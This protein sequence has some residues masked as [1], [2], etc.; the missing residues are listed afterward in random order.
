MVKGKNIL[1]YIKNMDDELIPISCGKSCTLSLQQDYIRATNPND[2]DWKYYLPT[3]RSWSITGNGLTDFSKKMGIQQL[4]QYLIDRASLVIKFEAV[5]EAGD[6]VVYTGVG[7]YQNNSLVG[8]AL[9]L[10][11]FSY[12]IIGIG[13]IEIQ[14][15]VPVDDGDGGGG[16]ENMTE[17]KRLQF[18]ATNGQTAYQNVDLIGATLLWFSVESNDLYKGSGDYEMAG[19]DSN[20]GVLTWNYQTSDGNE[21]IMLYKK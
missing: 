14:N 12:K 15:N 21:C 3:E 18:K 11:A 2:S 19:L 6:A 1:I 10:S 4:Q 17:V 8:D 7:G 16:G 5:T 9:K 13:K 20:T